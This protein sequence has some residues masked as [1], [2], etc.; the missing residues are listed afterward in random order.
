MDRSIPLL[1]IGLVFGGGIGF[2]L[3]AANG[4]TLDGHDHSNPAHHAGMDHAAMDHGEGHDHD[5]VLS[6]PTGAEA[7][8][9]AVEI[10]PDPAT[11]WNLHILTEN[12]AYAPMRASLDHVPGEGHAHV[13]ANGVKLGRVYGPWVHLDAL[14]EGSVEITVTLNANDHRVLAVDGAPLE[15]STTVEN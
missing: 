5:E 4:I 12:F 3:A 8:T 11:G 6:L 2:T 7:P 13:Y 10:A 1:L 14:P 9:L 15:A